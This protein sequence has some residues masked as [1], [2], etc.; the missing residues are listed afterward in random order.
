[1]LTDADIRALLLPRRPL[2]NFMPEQWRAITALLP[3]QAS[4]RKP[5]LFDLLIAANNYWQDEALP[6][7]RERAR[8]LHQLVEDLQTIRSRIWE[9]VQ[10]E[11]DELET[12][13]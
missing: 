10:E 8:E 12:M 7:P 2:R 9:V 11:S 6:P 5:A 13:L 4:P 3:K 1:M